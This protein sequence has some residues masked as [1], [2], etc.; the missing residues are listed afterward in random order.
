MCEFAPEAAL[1]LGSVTLSPKLF[2]KPSAGAFAIVGHGQH[3]HHGHAF[4]AGNVDALAVRSEQ[5]E[6]SHEI[7]RVSTLDGHLSPSD[8][9]QGILP[10]E[11]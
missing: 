2:L 1:C 10:R 6:R 3:C 4:A 9:E 8:G 7:E 11:K 5:P